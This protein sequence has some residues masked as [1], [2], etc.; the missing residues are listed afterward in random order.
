MMAQKF[1]ASFFS[2]NDASK[3]QAK[4]GNPG[5]LN[6]YPLLIASPSIVV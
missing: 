6:G 1:S 2:N 5:Y 3:R 4:S